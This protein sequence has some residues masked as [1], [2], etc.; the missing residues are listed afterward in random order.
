M[1][2]AQKNNLRF[3]AIDYYTIFSEKLQITLDKQEK[4]IIIKLVRIKNLT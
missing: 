4:M 3:I 2:N 1:H